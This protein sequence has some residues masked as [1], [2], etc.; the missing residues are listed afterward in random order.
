[1]NAKR[2]LTV[3]LLVPFL[4]F[5]TINEAAAEHA[6]SGGSGMVPKIVNFV[7]LF[8]ALF[9]FLRKP[10]GAMLTNKSN[11]ARNLLA[12]ARSEREKA[13][14]RLAQARVQ[15]A[16]LENEA[17]RLKAQAFTD[18]KDETAR[19]KE[20]AV[21]ETERI[22]TLA[23]QEVA[24]RLKAGIWELKKYTAGLAADIAESKMKARLTE[25][26]QVALIDRSIDRL[27]TVHEESAAR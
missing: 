24:V 19:I 13:E 27:K 9:Y 3:L 6:E 20:A 15:A 8:G 2:A 11:L 25:A 1:M 16:A 10:V 14:G 4:T 26:D 22:R 21:K 5:A 12:A 7:I 23:T 17:A 18:G